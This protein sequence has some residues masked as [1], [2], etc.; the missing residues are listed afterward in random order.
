VEVSSHL[1]ATAALSAGEGA[2]GTHWIGGWVGS[3]TRLN[4]RKYFNHGYFQD[5]LA[6]SVA[7][8]VIKCI[9]LD[10]SFVGLSH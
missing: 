3:K 2:L 9:I 6:I 1:H 5:K 10:F 4:A 8:L 7:I